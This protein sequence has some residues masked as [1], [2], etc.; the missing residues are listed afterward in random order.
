MYITS[1]QSAHVPV[2]KAI[3]ADALVIKQ[4]QEGWGLSHSWLR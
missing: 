4:N 1:L 3:K 2:Y